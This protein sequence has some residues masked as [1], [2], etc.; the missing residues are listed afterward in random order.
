[1]KV[2]VIGANG[3][4]GTHLMEQLQQ[5]KTHQAVAMVRKPEQ[6]DEWQNK[7]FSSALLD[8]EASVDD[9]TAALKGFEA[10]V[11]TAGSGGSTGDDK[12]LL[13]DL[14]GAVKA[15]EACEALPVKRFVMVSAWQAGNRDHWNE[16]LKPYYAAKHYADKLLM[17]SSLDWTVVRPGA[18]VDDKATGKVTLGDYVE[19]DQIPRSDVAHVLRRCLDDRKLIGSVFDVVSGD[20]EI[21]QALR[22]L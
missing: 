21:E 1:M 14:D 9:I 8:L 20:T 19:P 2:A 22:A 16:Q 10:V 7:G 5:A 17:A 11:F 6:R 3:K 12:T 15:V 18:L 4:I 13:I